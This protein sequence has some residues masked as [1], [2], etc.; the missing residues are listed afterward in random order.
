[1]VRQAHHERKR[2]VNFCKTFYHPKP[3][4]L[5]RI[6]IESS[7]SMMPSPTATFFTNGPTSQRVTSAL[8]SCIKPTPLLR[9]SNA[10]M[11]STTPRR[12]LCRRYGNTGAPT[13]GGRERGRLCGIR[14]TAAAAGWY[15]Y[16][17]TDGNAR[18][19]HAGDICCRAA[20]AD[21]TSGVAGVVGAVHGGCY[22]S[23]CTQKYGCYC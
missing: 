13:G 20:A 16:P 1:M 23:G 21:D 2:T 18:F 12:S 4:A 6:S 14:R 22:G 7:T 15:K 3:T 9:A 5:R 11:I 17:L 8:E 19:G 10:S